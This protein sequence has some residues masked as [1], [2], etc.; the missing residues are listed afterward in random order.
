MI[1]KKEF[2]LS[3]SALVDANLAKSLTDLFEKLHLPLRNYSSFIQNISVF[4]KDLKNHR[5][6][7]KPLI[8]GK[9]NFYII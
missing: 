2:F 6:Y 3:L 1:L 8:S 5:K 9:V 4:T 7:F